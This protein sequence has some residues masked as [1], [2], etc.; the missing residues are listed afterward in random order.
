METFGHALIPASWAGPCPANNASVCK[1]APAACVG[2]RQL[3]AGRDSVRPHR[4]SDVG[5]QFRGHHRPLT[6]RR[7]FNRA[8]FAI[9][10]KLLRGIDCTSARQGNSARQAAVS[11]SRAAASLPHPVVMG[12]GEAGI[13]NV[14]AEQLPQTMDIVDPVR[15]KAQL[16]ECATAIFGSGDQR[17]LGR[18]GRAPPRRAQ[19][20][21]LPHSARR[22][23]GSCG[24]PR[25]R[26]H[27]RRILRGLP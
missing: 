5:P 11:R 7:R 22:T 14:A 13:L 3:A 23:S 2:T 9:A 24:R 16:W 8:T 27:V 15:S 10:H 25:E 20:G 19:R 18:L 26:R 6:G 17:A 1:A 4:R 21:Y 12:D